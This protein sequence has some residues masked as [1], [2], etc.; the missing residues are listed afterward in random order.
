MFLPSWQVPF[1]EVTLLFLIFL[2]YIQ[3]LFITLFCIILNPIN[4]SITYPID[5]FLLCAFDIVDLLLDRVDPCIII[6]HVGLFQKVL[7]L[8]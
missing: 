3:S 5:W 6:D 7:G 4:L 8:V 1:L 2:P